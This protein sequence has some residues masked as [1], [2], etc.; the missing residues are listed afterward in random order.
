MQGQLTVY[1]MITLDGFFKGVGGDISW[2]IRENAEY[3]S[4]QD[5]FA[6]ENFSKN[7]ILVFGR[8]T[9]D[10]MSSF[11][12]SSM[13]AN[14]DK[15]IVDG[16]NNSEKLVFSKKLKN[17]MWKNTRVVSDNMEAE[18]KK[19]KKAGKN[20][21][22]LGSGS[23]ISPL[24]KAQLIDEIQLMIVPVAIGK[25]TPLFEGLS[26]PVDFKV[27][28]TKAFNNGNLLIHYKPL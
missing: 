28:K 15:R 19:L 24:L 3:D 14:E 7:N 6:A 17:P 11:W 25:G 22:I 12:P 10:L 2:H 4:E 9:Y 16:M 18:I 27:S 13:A 23:L 20:L 5:D 1:N 26:A 21:T 8:A